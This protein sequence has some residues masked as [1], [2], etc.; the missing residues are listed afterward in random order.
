MD[1]VVDDGVAVLEVLALG[2]AVGADED[3]Q[4]ARLFG[5]D[6]RL[7]LGKGREQ[8]Q[9]ALE[10]VGL[11][12]A[13]HGAQC[14][15]RGIAAGDLAHMYLVGLDQKVGEVV[16]EVVRGVGEGREDQHLAIAGIDGRAELAGD[17]RFEVLELGVVLRGDLGHFF[18]QFFDEDE[19]GGQVLLPARHVHVVEVDLDL[20]ADGVLAG[21]GD[22][23]II[24]VRVFQTSR[25]VGKAAG[26]T[27]LLPVRDLFQ[28]GGVAALQAGERE[29][30]G[31]NG[32]FQALE[33]VHRHQGLQAFLAVYLLELGPAS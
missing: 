4:L 12:A 24:E 22:V 2:D 7:L 32:A 20:L 23:V 14:G 29:A 19:V 11:A 16:V 15:V 10:V 27:A 33:Q 18:Q 13:G 25:D 1:V 3:V 28:G 21:H 8:R 9:Q 26:D 30:K 17:L 6:Q 5:V 31:F